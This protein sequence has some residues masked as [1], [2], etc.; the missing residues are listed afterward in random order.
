ETN[1]YKIRICSSEV[2]ICAVSCRTFCSMVSSLDC[3]SRQ[4][5]T[6]RS[7]RTRQDS[8]VVRETSA[9][10]EIS[11][12]IPRLPFRGSSQRNAFLVAAPSS[13]VSVD[14]EGVSGLTR[15]VTT[16]GTQ[17]AVPSGV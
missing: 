3:E 4:R 5:A 7:A 2:P 12:E 14:V 10:L 13:E 11:D 15:I 16:A 6:S 8:N 17:V 1:S 9:E